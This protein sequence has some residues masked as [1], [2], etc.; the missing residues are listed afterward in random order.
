M[1]YVRSNLG[2]EHVYA[3]SRLKVSQKPA[4]KN[5]EMFVKYDRILKTLTESVL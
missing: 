3:I 4:I 1:L 5:L 2:Y